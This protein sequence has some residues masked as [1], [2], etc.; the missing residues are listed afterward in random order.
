MYNSILDY[1]D[2]A[3]KVLLSIVKIYSNNTIIAIVNR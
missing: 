2:T 1:F 3:N